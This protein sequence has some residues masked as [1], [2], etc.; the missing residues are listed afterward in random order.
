MVNNKF[1]VFVMEKF[2]VV[3]VLIYFEGL[4]FL[5]E[6]LVKNLD[7]IFVE[8]VVWNIVVGSL[9]WRIGVEEGQELI[10]FIY[11]LFLKNDVFYDLMVNE[12]F[13][14]SFGWVFVEEF[15]CMKVLIYQVNDVLKVLFDEVGMLFVDYKFE[16][17]CSGGEI[18]L[19]D[20]FS[21]DGCWIWDKEI[22]KKMDKDWFCQ[23]LGDVIEIYEEVG[24]CLGI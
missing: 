17:G 8:C 11:E 20:E 1:N 19:G 12:L 15:E 6:F 18:V 16:F 21:L 2:E 13:V 22:C 4:F 24:C 23:G 3:G 7:M 5:I 14:V 9:C 10:F